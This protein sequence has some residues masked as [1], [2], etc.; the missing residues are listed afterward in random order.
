MMNDFNKIVS[1]SKSKQC[2]YGSHLVMPSP[3]SK[4]TAQ[5]TA[6]Q[7][8]EPSVIPLSYPGTP[9]LLTCGND[10]SLMLNK[11]TRREHLSSLFLTEHV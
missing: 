9:R 11:E 5:A 7:H 10:G 1:P 4:L 2:W 3:R 8:S 6:I